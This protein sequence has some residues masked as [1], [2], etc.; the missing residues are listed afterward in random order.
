[1]GFGEKIIDRLERKNDI[2]NMWDIMMENFVKYIRD[3]KL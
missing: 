3:V 2:S 1:M